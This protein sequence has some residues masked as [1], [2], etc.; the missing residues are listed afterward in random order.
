MKK[1]KDCCDLKSC[2]LCTRCLPGWLSAIGA[3]RE[4]RHYKKGEVVFAEG[5]AVMGMFFLYRGKV[6]VHK[7]WGN[8]KQLILHFAKEGDMI[9]Y[10]GL[11]NDM[12]YPVTASALEDVIVCFIDMSF[13]ETTLQ[14]NQQLTYDLMKFYANELQAAEVRMRNL[15]H[16]DVK[17]RI[18]ETL[19][20][21]KRK[22]GTDKTGAIN[23]KLTKQDMASY[24][25]TV[26]ETFFRM[27]NELVTDKLLRQSG[28][29]ITI[30]K[31][32]KLEQLANV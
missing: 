29:A 22:F 30:L 18:A 26:Y 13:F 23:I 21:L 8:D 9:G 7:R 2:F 16:M 10:R 24:S 19:L 32:A 3:H 14:V 28:K 6:K 5:A 25:G 15:A 20:M 12:V 17:G 11:G 31:E 27:L 4:N 1:S